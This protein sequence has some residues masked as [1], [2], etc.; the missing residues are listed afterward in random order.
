MLYIILM[1]KKNIQTLLVNYDHELQAALDIR[2]RVFVDEQNV[3]IELEQDG[4]DSECT[5]FLAENGKETIGTARL[6]PVDKD[7][8]KIER[9]AVLAEYRGQ[10]I[11]RALLGDM[12]Q[13]ARKQ[14]YKRVV[15]HAQLSAFDFYDGAGFK[16]I[17]EV[18][19]E[20]NISHV[21]MRKN[22]REK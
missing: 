17:G 22:L 13:Y 1:Q 4:K 20:A 2:R 16:Q 10:G 14:G 11:G 5:H 6:R 21:K 3:P 18:F 8:V 19:Y 9:M 7:T 12:L 15:L